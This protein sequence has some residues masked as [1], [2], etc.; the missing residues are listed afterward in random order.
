MFGL[1]HPNFFMYKNF[2]HWI[3]DQ[4]EIFH[5]VSKIVLAESWAI[6]LIPTIGNFNLGNF[7]YKIHSCSALI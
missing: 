4:A 2:G 5:L 3:R 1:G 7:E 6:G